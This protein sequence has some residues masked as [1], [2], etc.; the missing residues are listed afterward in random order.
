MNAPNHPRIIVD[1]A[2]YGGMPMV[3]GTRIA[4]AD[5]VRL[6]RDGDT[7]ETLARDFPPLTVADVRACREYGKDMVIEPDW[8]D[9][10]AGKFDEEF[11]RLVLERPG[12]D[13]YERPDI[14]FD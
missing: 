4:V 2:V 6:L 9:A 3:R 1:P 5:V 14:S 12:P 13:S 8:I 7:E 10:M 11:G